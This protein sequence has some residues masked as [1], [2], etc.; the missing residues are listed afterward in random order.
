[1]GSI[2]RE[3]TYWQYKCISCKLLWIKASA[4]CVN[5]NI[6]THDL[7]CLPL[8]QTISVLFKSTLTISSCLHSDHR[9]LWAQ[10]SHAALLIVIRRWRGK[11]SK[12][13]AAVTFCSETTALSSATVSYVCVVER[14]G[15][16]TYE[17]FLCASTK[18][19]HP[20]SVPHCLS[21]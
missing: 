15:G 14:A 20:G 10:H 11:A 18:I 21:L 2:P 7:N 13:P 12:S 5:V 4:K 3:H 6:F 1:M 8:H 16:F 17:N 9:S 19:L